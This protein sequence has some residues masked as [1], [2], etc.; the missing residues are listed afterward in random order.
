MKRIIV[1]ILIL[2]AI[3]VSAASERI[4]RYISSIHVNEDGSMIVNEEIT[5]FAAGQNIKRG[6]YRD[7]PLYYKDRS[8]NNINVQ[9]EILD[10]EKDGKDEPFHTENLRNGLRIYIGSKDVY[11]QRGYYTYTISYR[12]DRQLG[13]FDEHDELYWNVTG[14]GWL[15]PIEYARCSIFLP[16]GIGPDDIRV[17]A[18]TGAMGE[19]GGSY[20]ITE[21]DSSF[22]GFETTGRLV[23]YEGMTVVAG[24]PKGFVQE[25]TDMERLQYFLSDNMHLF[26]AVIG[27]VLLFIYY[28]WA[29]M[30]VGKD[31]ARGTIIPL[32]EAPEGLS[33]GGLR[34]IMRMGYDNKV[35]TS[36][37][38]NLGVKGYIKI[39]EE[40][41]KF[42]VSKLKE[43][44]DSLAPDEKIV[45]ENIFENSNTITLEKKN[46][47]EIMSTLAALR[48][49]LGDRYK[50]SM[51]FL[52][53]KY[54][55]PAII[56]SIATI[57]IAFFS[58]NRISGESMFLYIWMSFWTIGVLVMANAGIKGLR[59][60]IG[61]SD[62]KKILSSVV[63]MIVFL[64]FIAIEIIVLIIFSRNIPILFNVIVIIMIGLHAL[65]F[66]LLKAPSLAGRRIMDSIEGF[67]MY[68]SSAE[69][70]TVQM[71]EGPPENID[72][73]EKFLPF[74]FALDAD[75]KWTARFQNVIDSISAQQGNAYH[76]VWYTGTRS[77]SN[78]GFASSLGSSINS[79]VASS[80][81]SSSSSGFSG[82]SSGGGGGGG[83]GGGW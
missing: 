6:I 4:T 59:E 38:M 32:Y 56:I 8:G 51:F 67:K 7:F 9:F 40:N 12:T 46:R 48:K 71:H 65:F 19:T 81:S 10:I 70:D 49:E 72:T 50:N 60:G 80:S 41:R 18:F 78:A 39:S 20:S 63:L 79:A 52:N 24:W 53:T 26:I 61:S 66:D 76:P 27:L 54:T 83:G 77:F 37:I 47:L 11:L 44:D 74:A 25:P 43:R 69:K 58:S 1:L 55:V 16:D 28:M 23:S 14:N 42:T 17:D 5:V 22:V 3:T 45:M 31:P 62:S 73:Y 15:F 30:K 36:I 35:F 34:Y 2:C 82:G 33:P 68:L 75:N 13:F 29:W 21:K 64:P 57:V